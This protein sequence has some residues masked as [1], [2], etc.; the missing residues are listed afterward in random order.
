MEDAMMT[1]SM[2][3]RVLLALASSAG[4]TGAISTPVTSAKASISGVAQMK[5]SVQHALPPTPNASPLLLLDEAAGT[6]RSTGNT[7]YMQGA[8]VINREIANLVQGNGPH[9]GYITLAKGS[10]TTVSQWEGKVITTLGANNQP[11]TR[12]QGKWTM[13]RGT[14]KYEG[15]TGNGTYEGQIL[16]PSD[17][18]L[19]WKGDIV[20]D[21]RASR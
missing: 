21:Q 17:Y 8:A 19:T 14:G 13:M 6:N 12:F 15:T 5:Y 11:S 4:L 3:A 16:S 2:I 7:D 10:D 1:I 18:T 20:L 9:S